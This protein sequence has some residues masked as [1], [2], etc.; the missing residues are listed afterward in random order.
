MIKSINNVNALLDA[1]Q[2]RNPEDGYLDIMKAIGFGMN[3]LEGYFSWNEDNPTRN[4]LYKNDDFELQLICWEKGQKSPIHDYDARNAWVHVVHGQLKEEKFIKNEAVGQLEKVSS[5]TLGK[6]DFSYLSNY[7][8]IHRYSN[9]YSARTIS[10][11]LY[12]RPISNWK[13]YQANMI[14]GEPSPVESLDVQL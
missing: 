12:S 2:H 9:I 13:V 5:I 3:E 7:V 14:S 4:C 1:L 6:N 10:L 11:H 8:G